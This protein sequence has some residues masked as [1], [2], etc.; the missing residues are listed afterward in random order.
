LFDET[1]KEV[2]VKAPTLLNSEEQENRRLWILTDMALKYE[3]W[4]IQYYHWCIVLA[5]LSVKMKESEQCEKDWNLEI[6][7]M[8]NWQWSEIYTAF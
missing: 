5:I 4:N 7:Y 2:K 8:T 1:Y 3:L 6:H